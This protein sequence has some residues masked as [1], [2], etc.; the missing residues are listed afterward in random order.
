[1]REFHQAEITDMNNSFT[2]TV[3]LEYP[4]SYLGTLPQTT[5]GKG[6]REKEGKRGEEGRKSF[7]NI[8]ILTNFVTYLPCLGYLASILCNRELL[9]RISFRK[10]T[11]I[12]FLW[13]IDR[14]VASVLREKE[15]H[16]F[17]NVNEKLFLQALPFLIAHVNTVF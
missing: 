13:K 8:H 15:I 6:E 1:M 14:Q 7:T 11:V 10:N 4:N 9:V 17:M 5:V 3:I 12:F 2:R 16:I